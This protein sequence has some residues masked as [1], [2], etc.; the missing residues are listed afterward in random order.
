MPKKIWES[1]VL[2]EMGARLGVVTEGY[3]PLA[4]IS[5]AEI[6]AIIQ[7][8]YYPD[9]AL[10]GQKDWQ[11]LRD[12]VLKHAPD[13]LA[14]PPA[15]P[16]SD[17]FSQFSVQ[18]LN[19]DQRKGALTTC[20]DFHDSSEQVFIGNGYGELF[21]YDDKKGA[22]LVQ[23]SPSAI[24]SYTAG[25]SR[26]FLLE[27]GQMTPTEVPSGSL[28][29]WVAGKKTLLINKLH[30]PVY[31]LAQDMNSDGREE[32]LIAEYGNF[33]GQLSLVQQQPDGR[34][35]KE[36]LLNVP[37]ILRVIA[38]DMDQDGRLDL[39]LMAAQGDE[40]IY[41]L[42]QKSDLHFQQHKVLRFNPLYGSSWFELVDINGD[43]Q[44]DIIT[45]SG[46][47]AD[48]SYTTKP[49]HGVR[50]YLNDGEN[51]F[52]E[53]YFLAIP[54]ATQVVASDFDQDGDI[55]IG[56]GCFFPDYERQALS[57]VYL[58]NTSS[59]NFSFRPQTFTEAL[60]GR[61][62]L[63]KNIDYDRDGDEDILMGAFS[64]SITPAPPAL[65]EQWKNGDVDVAILK[66]R[67]R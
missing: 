66:N 53:H 10:I 52:A 45:A 51:G 58:E 35:Y 19:I 43:G 3:D 57:F 30:R 11:A 4:G 15:L 38:E 46:D 20:L 37:G 2:P 48:F 40:G 25:T 42:Y 14:V 44:Q 64:Y 7:K 5:Q 63:I 39:V 67:L 8:N 21:L 16:L 62:L 34:W 50:I 31:L 33:S 41:I 1:S 32:I 6:G 61:W 17:T 24:L 36:S 47:N 54:G 60:A 55:D 26:H 12:F 59:S 9:Q 13:S 23:R 49:Y 28:H 27:V 22:V 65:A 29:E 18:T 56:V